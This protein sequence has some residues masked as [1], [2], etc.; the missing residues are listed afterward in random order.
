MFNEDYVSYGVS[1]KYRTN[2]A[3]QAASYGA[4]AVLIRSVTPFSMN[5]PHTGYQ[6]Y[7]DN[8]TKIPTACITVEDANLLYRLQDRGQKIVLE[9]KMQSED[10]PDAISRNTIAEIPGYANPEKVVIVSGHLDSWD[11]GQGAMDDGGG[12]FIAWGALA[13]LKDMI[14]KRPKR[15]IRYFNLNC[16]LCSQHLEI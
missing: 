13:I 2:G 9:I 10:R 8:I 11:V 14:V 5:T 1:V 6:A 4:V 7:S 15:T 12:A 3:V 16:N